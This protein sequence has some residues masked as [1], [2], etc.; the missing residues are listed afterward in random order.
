MFGEDR[1]AEQLSQVRESLSQRAEMPGAQAEPILTEASDGRIKV[2]LGT[3]GRF[4]RIKMTLSAL[5]DGPDALVHQLTV[6]VNDAL[7]Q[8]AAQ[9]AAT[10]PAPD[11]A[12][13]NEQAARMQD[14]SVRQFQDMNAAIGD[15]MGRLYGGR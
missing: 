9:T 2:T 10:G 6:A 7:D 12:A 4:E 5:K 14:A 3:D 13:M 8:R 11:M 15:L 1:I